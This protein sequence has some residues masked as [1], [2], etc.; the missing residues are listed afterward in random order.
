ML[1]CLLQSGCLTLWCIAEQHHGERQNLIARLQ[2][3]AKA[4]SIRVSFV[5][6]DVHC[7]A[8]GRLYTHP[9]VHRLRHDHRFMPQVIDKNNT[10][11]LLYK[12]VLNPNLQ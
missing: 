3:L 4:K 10:A 9:K 2:N 5:G 7:A 11:L 12:L 1:F 8:I 6:G